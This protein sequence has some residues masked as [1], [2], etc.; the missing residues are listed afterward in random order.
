M[1]FLTVAFILFFLIAIRLYFLQIKATDCFYFNK[2]ACK[3]NILKEAKKRQIHLEKIIAQRGIIYDRNK[4]IL[5][6]S[7]PIKTLCIN[8]SKL[9]KDNNRDI[10]QLSKILNISKKDL[11]KIIYKHKNK[12][13]YYLKRHISKNYYLKIKELNNPYIYFINE[14]KRTYLGGKAFS[15]VIGFTNIDDKGQE[16]IEYV[17]DDLLSPVNGLKKVKKDNIGRSIETIKII[18]QPDSGKNIILT[19]DKRIQFIAYEVLRKYIDKFN[20]DSGSIALVEANTGNIL[21]MVNYPSFDPEKRN[22]YTGYKIKNRVIYDLIEPGSTIKPLIVYAGLHEG[23]ISESSVI[24]TAPGVI[25][26]E[27]EEIKD[28][29]Y[30]GKVTPRD[31]VRLSSNI[32][33]AKISSKLTKKKLIESLDKLGFGQSL[34]LNL[35]GSKTGSLPV[36]S[37]LSHSGHL[38]LGYGYGLSTSLM[39]LVSAYTILANHGNRIQLNYLSNIENNNY[40]KEK[41]LDKK[42]SIIVLDMMKDVVHSK[43]GT[44]R[45]ARVNGYTVY[46]KTGTVRQIVNSKYA[47]N[48]HNALFIGILGDP[49]PEYV[50][51]VIIRNPKNREG[52]GGI[53]AAP[54]FSEFMQHSMRIINDTTYATRK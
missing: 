18:K 28:W 5:A 9:Y 2:G 12:K 4:D 42:N 20:A 16:G 40:K 25:K 13:E 26:L 24:D 29:K 31:I 43:D 46:G 27:N 34:F 23:V 35:P 50:A 32:G 39:H 10:M 36:A 53:H 17:K 44:G 11:K 3:E 52:S 8:P 22:T 33:A 45:K 51:A 30:L 19:L 41:I 7:L 48:R 21:S 6:M 54:V 47:K 38:S 1:L 37:N 49:S 14:N 15:N